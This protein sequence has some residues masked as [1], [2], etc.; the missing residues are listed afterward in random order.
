MR[1]GVPNSD[2]PLGTVLAVP[3]NAVLC[4]MRAV[5]M[6][7]ALGSVPKVLCTLLGPLQSSALSPAM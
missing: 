7:D 6:R 5:A 4:S 2:V 1:Q 3:E